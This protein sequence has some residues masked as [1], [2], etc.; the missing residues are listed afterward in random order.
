MEEKKEED[1]GADAEA[2][3]EPDA[4]IIQLVQMLV[5][6]TRRTQG[7]AEALFQSYDPN[8]I[9]PYSVEPLGEQTRGR[10]ATSMGRSPSFDPASSSQILPIATVIRVMEHSTR[11]YE[12]RH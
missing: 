5:R 11:L 8:N 12:V 2:E 6:V 7:S 3:L 10:A 1:D 4:A 9:E